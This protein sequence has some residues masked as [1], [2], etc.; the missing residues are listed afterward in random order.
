[1]SERLMSMEGTMTGQYELARLMAYAPKVYLRNLRRGFGR[2]R[3]RYIGKPGKVGRQGVFRERLARKELWGGRHAG[4][5]YR[6]WTP[7][8]RAQFKGFIKPWGPA[9]IDN[10][11]LTMGMAGDHPIH[12]I[13][14]FLEHGGHISGHGKHL[15]I[16]I[17]R[18]LVNL[19]YTLK[20]DKE[21]YFHS[22]KLLRR[23]SKERDV[24]SIRAGGVMRWFDKKTA[25]TGDYGRAL[26]F[27]GVK[28][29]NIRPQFKFI[30]G[31]M[32]REAGAMRRLQKDVDRATAQVNKGKMQ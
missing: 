15:V 30:Q 28:A 11:T 2:E 17:Y 19:G 22:G 9:K 18:N 5:G 14:K 13:L 21:G 32:N 23:I 6:I 7:Q 27:I 12:K 29:I 1:M 31:W 16:P 25:E 10:L 8:V 20:S 26:L 24:F 4:G 3:N